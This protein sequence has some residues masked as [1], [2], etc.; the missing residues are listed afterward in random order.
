MKK[1]FSLS[2]FALILCFGLF[3]FDKIDSIIHVCDDLE[4]VYTCVTTVYDDGSDCF[5]I[6][7]G[8]QGCPKG[9]GDCGDM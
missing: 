4:G 5:W 8:C 9:Y 7:N 6:D 2:A 1:I 3:S